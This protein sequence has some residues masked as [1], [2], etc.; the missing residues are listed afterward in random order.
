MIDLEKFLMSHFCSFLCKFFMVLQW[1]NLVNSMIFCLLLNSIIIVTANMIFISIKIRKFQRINITIS[2][3]ECYIF[4]K[5]LISNLSLLLF[6][7]D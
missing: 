3:F 7:H 6:H 2:F 5:I 1:D 4:I